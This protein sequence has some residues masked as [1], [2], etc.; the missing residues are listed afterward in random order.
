VAHRGDHEPEDF[1]ETN[2]WAAF[3]V[4]VGAFTQLPQD[5]SPDFKKAIELCVGS[6]TIVKVRVGL[7][8]TPV[9]T[10]LR[11]F[12]TA[13]LHATFKMPC[14]ITSLTDLL[15]ELRGWATNRGFNVGLPGTPR[16]S[17]PFVAL[18][19]R[20]AYSGANLAAELER[21]AQGECQ[22]KVI[23]YLS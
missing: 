21:Y 4:G 2:Q 20:P 23:Q 14:R 6:T 13:P 3:L 22:V 11:A 8:V 17:V 10:P 12:T 19:L 1:A 18:E 5:L 9:G 7:L 15:T 16:G